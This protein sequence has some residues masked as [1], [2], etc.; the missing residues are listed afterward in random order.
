MR[1]ICAVLPANLAYGEHGMMA[2]I[3][4]R[5]ERPERLQRDDMIAEA[6]ANGRQATLGVLMARYGSPRGF[7]AGLSFRLE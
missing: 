1:A 5:S 2:A 3:G 6:I 7:T 4:G